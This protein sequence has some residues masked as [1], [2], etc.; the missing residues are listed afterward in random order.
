MKDQTSPKIAVIGAGMAGLTCASRL[1]QAGLSVSVFEKSRGIGGRI[2]TRR[3]S[4]D[5]HFDHGAQYFTA[6]TPAFQD[7]TSAP[8]IAG[9]L[10]HWWPDGRPETARSGW[11]VGR[12]SM[13]AFLKPVAAA[14]NLELGVQVAGITPAS[15]G[16]SL[17]FDG[18][19]ASQTYDAVVVT[20]PAP[21]ALALTAVSSQL[22]KRLALI[23]VAPCWAM[24]LSAGPHSQPGA[25]TP[26]ILESPHPDIAWMARNASKP[27][28]APEPETWVIHASTDYSL[29][30]LEED[31]ET[32]TAH[33][34]KIALP[35]T[36]LPGSAALHATSH[37]WRYARTI[38]AAGTPFL[39]DEAGTLLVAGDGCLGARVESAFT[40][41][42]AAADALARTFAPAPSSPLE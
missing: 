9:T 4:E 5:V 20:A 2:A 7:F 31:P 24:M 34:R 8:L 18:A 39:T 6:T 10:E 32:V 15:G 41:G 16:W 42:H 27:G 12:P 29:R 36:G 35:L 3:T 19:K 22:Q 33:L 1:A 30:H 11:L 13:N 26:S 38:R 37:R 25:T 17:R 40:S 28:R 14:L 23:E 21:Q